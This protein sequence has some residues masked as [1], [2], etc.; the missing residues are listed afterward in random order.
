MDKVLVAFY[1]AN[2]PFANWIDKL[3]A[4]WT[5]GPY[6]H[7]EIVIEDKT[8]PTGYRMYSSLGTE[9]GVRIK[10][11]VIDTE[12]WDYVEVTVYDKQRIISFYEMILGSKY[13]WTGIIFSQIVRLGVDNQKR[14]FCS[15]SN[16]KALQIAGCTNKNVWLLKPEMTHPNKLAK[17]LGLL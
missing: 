14:W 15:E 16:T 1:K 5:R 8:S 2:N 12:L 11:H 3:I 7:S 10:P 17:A 4:W 13:D 6:C 9:G